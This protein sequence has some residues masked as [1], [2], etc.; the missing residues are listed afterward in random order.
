M[1]K[2]TYLFV[3]LVVSIFIASCA[4]T[5]KEALIE[6]IDHKEAIISDISVVRDNQQTLKELVENY[7]TYGEMFPNDSVTPYYLFRAADISLSTGYHTEAMTLL[8]SILEKHPSFEKVP[9]CL[10]LKGY[11]EENF[12]GN[13]GKA[14]SYYEEFLQKYP[15]HAFA[16]DVR[17]TIQY[18]GKTPEEVIRE[19]ERKNNEK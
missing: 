14:K 11:I 12:F 8:N 9:H 18:L 15:N 2:S 6:E 17:M 1:R 16:G 7:Q 10:F 5:S 3:L 13:L 4:G 19:F